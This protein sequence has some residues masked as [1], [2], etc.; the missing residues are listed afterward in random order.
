MAHAREGFLRGGSFSCFAQMCTD[1]V[2]WFLQ[3]KDMVTRPLDEGT[4]RSCV[5]SATHSFRGDMGKRAEGETS[6]CSDD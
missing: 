3:M 2:R 1:Y 4:G 6:V 5:D